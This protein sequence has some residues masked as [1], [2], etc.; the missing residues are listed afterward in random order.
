MSRFGSGVRLLENGFYR[1]MENGSLRVLET[2]PDAVNDRR[3]RF[4][5]VTIR[6]GLEQYRTIDR[7]FRITEDGAFRVTTDSKFREARPLFH[8]TDYIRTEKGGYRTT[9][10]GNRRVKEP[11]RSLTYGARRTPDGRLRLTAEGRLRVLSSTIT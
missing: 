8:T 5:T 7:T 3:L 1:L 11:M 6:G 4:F 10:S 9:Q 2:T